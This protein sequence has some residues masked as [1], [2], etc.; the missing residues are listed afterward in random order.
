MPLI[1]THS[2]KVLWIAGRSSSAGSQ[3][4]YDSTLP[5]LDEFTFPLFPL[6]GPLPNPQVSVCDYDAVWDSMRSPAATQ[7]PCM[8]G[9][10]SLRSSRRVNRALST[11]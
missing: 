4:V 11:N 1:H 8:S 5:S 7:L 3:S 10:C 6:T 2:T 9:T